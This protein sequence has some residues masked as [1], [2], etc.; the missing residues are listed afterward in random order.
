MNELTIGKYTFK[1]I[2]HKGNY[3]IR[4]YRLNVLI[5]TI[6]THKDLHNH[7]KTNHVFYNE[8]LQWLTKNLKVG[9]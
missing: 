7:I 4:I 5:R 6:T 3:R 1:L 8:M 9:V 2:N